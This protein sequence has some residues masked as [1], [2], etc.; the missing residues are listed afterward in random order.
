MTQ[1]VASSVVI[2]MPRGDAWQRLKD[3]SLAHNYVPGIV[4]TEIVTDLREGVGASRYVYSNEKKYIQETVTEWREGEGFLIKLHRGDKRAPPFREASFRYLL[5]DAGSD[6]TRFTA[7]L[8]YTL[9]WG[10]IGR[11]LEKRMAGFG[12]GHEAVLRKRGTHHCRTAESRK[13]TAHG[14]IT[15]RALSPVLQLLQALATAWRST[16]P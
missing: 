11:W 4:R 13:G 6:Q 2:D 10:G 15:A 5:E 8:T 3:I 16:W 12:A 7:C 1:S 9:P 14:W